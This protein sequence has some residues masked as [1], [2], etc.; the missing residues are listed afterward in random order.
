[1]CEWLRRDPLTRPSSPRATQDLHEERASERARAAVAVAVAVVVAHR[2]RRR[3]RRSS[4]PPSATAAPPVVGTPPFLKTTR[5]GPTLLQSLHSSRHGQAP[6]WAPRDTPTHIST[7]VPC[8]RLFALRVPLSRAC[9]RALAPPPPSPPPQAHI[10]HRDAHAA[11]FPPLDPPAGG[12]P[13]TSGGT[14]PAAAAAA[15]TAW[16]SR[17]LQRLDDV[18]PHAAFCDEAVR[19][20]VRLVA[21]AEAGEDPPQPYVDLSCCF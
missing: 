15:S 13:P 19:E 16:S 20:G 2:R 8:R 14:A 6:P 5:G 7:T 1:M 10:A 17:P 21:R 9:A 11:A 12:A 3:R 4:S 18:D